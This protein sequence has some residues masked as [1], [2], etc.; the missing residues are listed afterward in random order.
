LDLDIALYKIKKLEN[1]RSDLV[2]SIND[3]AETHA[4]V[5]CELLDLRSLIN[6]EIKMIENMVG[7][8]FDC[9]KKITPCIWCRSRMEF[10]K[11]VQARLS[12]I[13]NGST[14]M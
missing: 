1:E 7:R 11:G 14:D 13:F 5:L 8:C 2:I 4:K 9:M 3:S 10:A 12:K 6:S